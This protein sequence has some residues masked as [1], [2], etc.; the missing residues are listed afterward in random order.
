MSELESVHEEVEDEEVH[1]MADE[2][3]VGSPTPPIP[4]TTIDMDVIIRG[5]EEKFEHLSRC[6]REV[7]LASE[8]ANSNMCDINRNGDY[9][10]CTWASRI[11]YRNV[12]PR[13]SQLHARTTLPRRARHTLSR[14]PQGYQSD[15]GRNLSSNHLQWVKTSPWNPRAARYHTSEIT[16]TFGVRAPGI[17]TTFG[18]RASENTTPSGT[19]APEIT[20]TFGT[21]ASEST[22]TSG[23]RA[24]ENMTPSGTRAPENTSM[25][26]TRA[27]VNS[28]TIEIDLTNDLHTRMTG[29]TAVICNGIHIIL[30]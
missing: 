26:G 23:T 16:T 27:P 20:T 15:C 11:S 8:K 19:R 9:K 2:P 29:G 17:T 4:V 10:P 28:T 21:R 14:R 24:S 30:V 12:S 22:T 18:T 3:R 7:Q 5:W 13:T 6:L 1:F 25:I